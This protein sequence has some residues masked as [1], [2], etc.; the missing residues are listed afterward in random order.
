M[1]CPEIYANLQLAP[2][3]YLSQCMLTTSPADADCQNKFNQLLEHL[4]RVVNYNAYGLMAKS[5]PK[6]DFTSSGD[7]YPGYLQILGSWVDDEHV[8]S[9]KYKDW[10]HYAT[11]QKMYFSDTQLISGLGA[12]FS[13]VC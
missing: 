9:K 2:R 12:I 6:H 13:F 11:N 1:V 3:A 7:N 10:Y 8:Q 5:F 4:R